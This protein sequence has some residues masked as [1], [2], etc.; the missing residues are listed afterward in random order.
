MK[1][2][3]LANLGQVMR[4]AWKLRQDPAVSDVCFDRTPEGCYRLMCEVPETTDE[5]QLLDRA[6][7][8]LRMAEQGYQVEWLGRNALVISPKGQVYDGDLTEC[9]CIDMQMR[10]ARGEP[11]TYKGPCKHCLFRLLEVFEQ[12]AQELVAQQQTRQR[13]LRTRRQ[14]PRPRKV[15]TG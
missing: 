14:V 11:G 5:Q 15:R 13:K 8:A 9:N 12:A 3:T 1:K 10:Q 2:F 6:V 7:R 4:L